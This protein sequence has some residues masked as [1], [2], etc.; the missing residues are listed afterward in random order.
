MNAEDP[1]RREGHLESRLTETSLMARSDLTEPL[2]VC[3]RR[4]PTQGGESAVGDEK[5]EKKERHERC[6]RGS[7]HARGLV[8]PLPGPTRQRITNSTEGLS[9]V[10]R[11]Y[12]PAMSTWAITV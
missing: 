5:K 6:V 11:R 9:C 7:H 3:R 10:P 8:E 4:W 1:R 12:L 2:G